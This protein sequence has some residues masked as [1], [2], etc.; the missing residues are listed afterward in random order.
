MNNLPPGVS[1][2]DLDGPVCNVCGRD[3]CRHEDD[4]DPRSF[5]ERMED[6]K[7]E[8]RGDELDRGQ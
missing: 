6:E 3:D 8:M 5:R 1:Q 2:R 7:A 4:G